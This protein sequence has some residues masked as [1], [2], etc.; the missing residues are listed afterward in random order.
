[1]AIVLCQMTTFGIEQFTNKRFSV[2]KKALKDIAFKRKKTHN[3][4][5]YLSFHMARHSFHS[6]K[7][8]RRFIHGPLSKD[9]VGFRCRFVAGSLPESKTFPF[10]NPRRNPCLQIEQKHLRP[11]CRVMPC[12]WTNFTPL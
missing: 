7:R 8:F 2:C 1:M 4:K 10:F 6:F 5:A 11:P 3:K 9:I 12:C